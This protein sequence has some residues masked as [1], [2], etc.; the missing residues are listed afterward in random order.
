M[1]RHWMGPFIL[2]AIIASIL[3]FFSLRIEQKGFLILLRNYYTGLSLIEFNKVKRKTLGKVFEYDISVDL[4]KAEEKFGSRILII[5][6]M[7][8]IIFK[9]FAWALSLKG[10][11]LNLITSKGWQTWHGRW[12]VYP[13]FTYF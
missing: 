7:L 10:V 1:G 4:L 5:F 12:C 3:L 8:K 9:K 11:T 2:G 6:L 13:F